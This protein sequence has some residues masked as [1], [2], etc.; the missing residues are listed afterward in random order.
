MILRSSMSINFEL[1]KTL[2][3]T[4]HPFRDS[5]TLFSLKID[6]LTVFIYGPTPI[7]Y[8]FL[9]DECKLFT[10]FTL[11]HQKIMSLLSTILRFFER[12]I[13]SETY[14][15]LVFCSRSGLSPGTWVVVSSSGRRSTT[16][17]EF[18]MHLFWDLYV[19]K[20]SCFLNKF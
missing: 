19:L 20:L 8:F 15:L 17:L 9:R 11:F 7:F 14:H 4:V 2:L 13:K 6:L 16:F 10:A 18:E 12:E 3:F 5:H 1:N